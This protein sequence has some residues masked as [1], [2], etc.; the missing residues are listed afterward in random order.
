MTKMALGNCSISKFF[1]NFFFIIILIY[2]DHHHH[3]ILLLL[4]LLFLL[5]HHHHNHGLRQYHL[6]SSYSFV[7]LRLQGAS[8]HF[9]VGPLLKLVTLTI[10]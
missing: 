3:H 9:T 4:L 2:H 1:E 7:G 8:V 10:I 5:N 6:L